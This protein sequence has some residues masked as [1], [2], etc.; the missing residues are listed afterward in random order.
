MNKIQKFKFGQSGGG[1]VVFYFICLLVFFWVFTPSKKQAAEEVS[2]NVDFDWRGAVVDTNVIYEYTTVLPNSVD[3]DGWQ[4]KFLEDEYN[5]KIDVLGNFSEEEVITKLP[6]MLAGGDVPD[7][8]GAAGDY[9]RSFAYHEFRLPLPVENLNEY[10]PTLIRM[11]SEYAPE[12]WLE[13]TYEG[14]IYGV[15]LGLWY[16][17]MLPRSGVWR[18]DILETNG[19]YEVPVTIDDMEAAFEAVCYDDQGNRT[20][21]YGMTGDI[22]NHYSTF[23]EVFGAFGVLPFSWIVGS[24]GEVIWGGIDPRAEDALKLLNSWYEKG[25]IHPDFQIDKWYSQG[26]RKFCNGKT[27]YVNYATSTMNFDKSNQGSMVS[28]LKYMQPNARI[29]PAVP[30]VGPTGEQGTHVWGAGSLSM[31]VFGKHL[32]DEP[33]KVIKIL[34]ILESNLVNS[35]LYEQTKF[36]KRGVHWDWDE[37]NGGIKFLEPYKSKEV[38]R[39]QGLIDCIP[40][41]ANCGFLS[42]AGS[43]EY[44]SKYVPRSEFEWNKKNSKPEW[45]KSDIFRT[46]TNVK[47]ADKY[48]ADLIELQQVA[49]V[50]IITGEKPIDYFDE[51]VAQWKSVGGDVMLENAAKTYEFNQG[52][53]EEMKE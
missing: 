12:G 32:A 3:D 40:F 26:T 6:L 34:Q 50:K 28:M 16:S 7:F 46:A 53:V 29:E 5:I 23:S 41:V 21:M 22:Q 9:L 44:F 49:Y 10:C 43:P 35:T 11:V 17:G 4:I 13:C 31:V 42:P 39:A 48:M 38:R 45:G 27:A 37:E 14:Q 24:N 2:L 33:E 51:F 20:S 30:P 8:F 25:Y 52:L 47:D 15:P 18:M 36:G 1:L 19:I